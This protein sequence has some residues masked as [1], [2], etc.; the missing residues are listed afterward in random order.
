MGSLQV[1]SPAAD[2]TRGGRGR[3]WK[4]RGTALGKTINQR[5]PAVGEGRDVA[6]AMMLPSP[7]SDKATRG[8]DLL[9]LGG[10]SCLQ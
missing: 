4:E 7:R 2:V 3:G 10:V 6:C 5:V 1:T 8:Q 9:F